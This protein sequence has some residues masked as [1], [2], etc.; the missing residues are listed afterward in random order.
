MRDRKREQLTLVF[1][2]FQQRVENFKIACVYF[3]TE[4]GYLFSAIR[5]LYPIVP[6]ET[7]L[8]EQEPFIRLAA[9]CNKNQ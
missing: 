8:L 7:P 2:F 4:H 9:A 1:P 5:P 6:N 3:Y